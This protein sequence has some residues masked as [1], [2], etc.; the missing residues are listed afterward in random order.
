MPLYFFARRYLAVKLAL[1]M[2]G[3]PHDAPPVAC[4]QMASHGR[5]ALRNFGLGLRNRSVAPRLVNGQ[6]HPHAQL[7]A[8][9]L[10]LPEGIVSRRQLEIRVALLVSKA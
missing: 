5:A 10:F 6:V 4:P 3:M 2:V 7:G 8:K 1:A 9:L